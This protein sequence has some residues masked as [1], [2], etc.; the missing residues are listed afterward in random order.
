VCASAECSAE[1]T[2]D[3]PDGWY[4]L[5]VQYFDLLHGKSHFS[6]SISGNEVDAWDA[7]DTLPS[8]KLN[9]HTSTRRV[10]RN[11]AIH[12]GDT[13]RVTGHPDGGE[14]APLDYV[15]ISPRATN[16]EAAVQREHR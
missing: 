2:W 7:D 12:H 13:V 6:L 9:G 16:S 14:K 8:D 3:G 1:T 11:A 10:L 4:D 5:T 15:E